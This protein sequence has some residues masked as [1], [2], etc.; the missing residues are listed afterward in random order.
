M[1]YFFLIGLKPVTDDSR[2]A[3][4]IRDAIRVYGL[5]R[6]FYA[7]SRDKFHMSHASNHLAVEVVIMHKTM[8]FSR[9]IRDK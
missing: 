4:N 2:D 5:F 3:K 1:G 9:A 7:T 8:R 6:I